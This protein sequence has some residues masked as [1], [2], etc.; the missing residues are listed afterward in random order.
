MIYP[1]GKTEKCRLTEEDCLFFNACVR[2]TVLQDALIESDAANIYYT[3]P[4]YSG[5]RWNEYPEEPCH[6]MSKKTYRSKAIEQL[7]AEGLL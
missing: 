6:A 5:K 1:C 2:I 3:S 7:H 4:G